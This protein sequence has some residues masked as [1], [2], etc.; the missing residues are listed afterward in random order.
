M[1]TPVNH[2]C[3]A[4]AGA[5]GNYLGVQ[6]HKAGY[7]ISF[8][9]SE[10]VA[11]A[12]QQHGLRLE[13]PDNQQDVFQP[14]ALPFTTD[15]R[16][17]EQ[18]D[19]VIVTAKSL[20][21]ES[22]ARQIKPFLRPETMVLTLQNGITN[23]DQ[24]RM[25]LNQNRVDGGMV[26]FNAIEKSP[27]VYRL[28]TS[29]DIHLQQARPSL[30]PVFKRAGLSAREHTD[31]ASMLWSKLLLNL[32]NP[33]NALS[34]RSLK[35]NLA[36]HKFRLHWAACMREGISVLDAAGIKPA[37]VTPLPPRLLPFMVSLPNWIY[38]RL[39]NNMTDMDPTAKSSMAQ[40][41]DKRKATEIDYLSGEIIRL[42]EQ[43]AIPTPVNKNVYMAIK[44]QERLFH[45]QPG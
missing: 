27:A 1:S 41:L 30:L 45:E 17:C 24:L 11:S 33:L 34:G 18:A 20:V 25:I 10:R 4:G 9:A 13:Y 3:I 8:L 44:Q 6:L 28:T 14:G 22:I 21:T 42:G 23:A 36:D 12:V 32:V 43:Y 35:D 7:V 19:L 31:L 5:I 39:A 2:I 26:T 15:P 16:C 38:L 37:K 29:G 40:D